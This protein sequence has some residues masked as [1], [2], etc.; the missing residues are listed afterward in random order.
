MTDLD[1]LKSA[2]SLTDVALMLG[3]TPTGLAHTLYIAPAATRYETFE[4]PKSDGSARVINAPLGAQRLAQ[5]KLAE[6]LQSCRD[7]VAAT[8]KRRPLS[9]AFRPGQSIIT[10]ARVHTGR[11]Y[12]L[13]VD[14]EDFFPSLNFGRVRGFFIKDASFGL[15]PEV[16]TVIAQIACWENGLPQGSP[17]SPI[18]SDLITHILDARLA[19]LAKNYGLAY[20][21]YADDLTFST[22]RKDFPPAV[23]SVYALSDDA[24]AAGDQLTHAIKSRGFKVNHAKTRMQF[25]TSRQTVTGLT[26]NRKVNVSQR[27]YRSV[28]AMCHSLFNIGSYTRR[29]PVTGV[30]ESVSSLDPIEGMLTHVHHVKRAADFDPATG[31]LKAEGA[32]GV[33]HLYDRFLF[34]KWFAAPQVPFIVCEGT[35]DN[36]YLR[37]AVRHIAALPPV[38]GAMTATGFVSGVR[39]FNYSNKTHRMTNLRGGSDNVAKLIRSY[40]ETIARYRHRPM[41]HP[42]IL[43]IDNDSGASSVLGAARRYLATPPSL[44]TT[45]PFYFL[46][47]NLYLVKTPEAAGTGTSCIE[48]L[49][50]SGLRAT[51]LDGKVFHSGNKPKYDIEYDKQTF[52]EKVVSPNAATLNWAG[53]APL[54]NRISLAI[55]DYQTRLAATAAG[56]PVVSLGP[57]PATGGAP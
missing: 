50:D 35:T 7:E 11:R 18:I 14:L 44:T 5:T 45:E 37:L 21:R 42:V 43:V 20:S 23:A 49:F 10:N 47:A 15:K 13:N 16:A 6:L 41:A 17:S 48:D 25:R 39:F 52:L 19:R 55:I 4:I 36:G 3:F 33:R 40:H 2:T 32:P 28:R 12:V 54:L 9:H 24:W 46:G 51:V 22:N 30:E 1:R 29:N 57:A 34:Y 8:T 56:A 38:L 27:Y 26:V 53:F 31:E